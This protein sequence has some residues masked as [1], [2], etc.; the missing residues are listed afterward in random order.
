MKSRRNQRRTQRNSRRRKSR[1]HRSKRHRGGSLTAIPPGAVV[2][3]RLDPKDQY[4]IPVTVGR[5]TAEKI[6]DEATF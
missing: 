5:E 2:N 6:I 3:M 1:S 4:S